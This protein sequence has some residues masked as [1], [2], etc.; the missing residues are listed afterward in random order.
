[1]T[2][3]ITV[4]AAGVLLVLIGYARPVGG[5]VVTAAPSCGQP[6]PR[7][8]ELPTANAGSRAHDRGEASRCP[9]S[10]MRHGPKRPECKR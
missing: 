5:P 1:M 6:T 4:I 8:A 2:G 7:R 3:R 10:G 9:A